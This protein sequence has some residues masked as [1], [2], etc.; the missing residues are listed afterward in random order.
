MLKNRKN[1]R[2]R[3]ISFC[4]RSGQSLIEILIALA[5]GALLIGAAAIGIMFMIRATGTNQNLQ[6]ASGLVREVIEK[7][8]AWSGADWQNVYALNKGLTTSYFLTATGTTFQVIKGEEGMV[9]GDV[10][11]GLL[12]R[13]GFDEATGTVAYD[14][15]INGVN[16][17]LSGSPVRATS[18]SC[19]LGGCL[20]FDGT[21]FVSA[22]DATSTDPTTAWTLSAWVMR[23]ATGTQHSIIEKYDNSVGFGNFAMRVT[24]GD[25]L[26]ALVW[27]GTASADCGTTITTLLPNVWYYVAAT[28]NASANRLACFVN[29]DAESTNASVSIDPPASSVVLRVGC[30]G[31]DCG[32]K[33]EGKIDDARLYDR[34]LSA[35][36]IDRISRSRMFTRFFSIENTC[37]SANASSSIETTPCSGGY[38]SDP[39]TQKITAVVRWT[40]AQGGL[41]EVKLVEFLTRW[42][43]EVFYQRD[44]SGGSGQ[45]GPIFTPNNRFASSTNINI[46]SQG[47]IKIQGL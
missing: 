15:S 4:G 18:T 21:N 33:F 2:S 40:N 24:S 17:T 47:L 36:E 31:N 14:M 5:I 35:G 11:Y 13:W 19:K 37:R 3:P 41:G 20:Q 25:K 38:F 23:N 6:T 30:R 43:N 44:W 7:L 12:G 46:D 34:A 10:R 45:E 16:G 27:D 28:F 39:S 42:K 8:R 22:P 9:E 1:F 26:T 32:T 29:G